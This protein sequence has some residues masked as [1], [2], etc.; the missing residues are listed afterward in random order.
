[1]KLALFFMFQSDG[2]GPY[3]MSLL[4]SSTVTL[5]ICDLMERMFNTG[6]TRWRENRL[7]SSTNARLEDQEI[8]I[9]TRVP[10]CVGEN[11]CMW[12]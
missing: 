2:D 11:N 3:E 1:M 4:E 7:P 9:N 5:L 12:S 8:K 10:A 6:P